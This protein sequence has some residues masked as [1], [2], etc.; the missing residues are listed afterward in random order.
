ME[1]IRIH[2]RVGLVFCLVAWIGATAGC[3]SQP[4]VGKEPPPVVPVSPAIKTP[5][6]TNRSNFPKI[7]ALGDSLTAGYGLT[8]DQAFPAQLQKKLDEK[9][10]AYEVVNAGVSG[11]T[12]A[13]GVSRLE[14]SLEGNVRYVIVELGGNDGLRGLP[15]A[16]LKRNLAIIIEKA[17]KKGIT[18]I[19]TGMEA[20][21]NYGPDYIKEFHNVYG[22]LARQYKT[23][24]VPFFL[25]GVAGKTELNQEDGIHP[26]PAGVAIVTQNVWSVLEPT[27]KKD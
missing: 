14:W 22:D 4:S 23:P 12:S 2:V 3:T 8:I 25:E 9:G 1:K 13:G 27:L 15:V 5:P 10:F 17:Q 18:V 11:D 26:N 20:P 24:F 6:A 19:L 16:E 7:V 21:P